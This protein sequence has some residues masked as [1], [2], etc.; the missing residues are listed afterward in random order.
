MYILL[1]SNCT[2]YQ[3]SVLIYV[4]LRNIIWYLKITIVAE[5]D[6]CLLDVGCIFLDCSL[7]LCF[8]RWNSKDSNLPPMKFLLKGL[9][10]GALS[11]LAYLLLH[12][13]NCHKKSCTIIADY[14][15]FTTAVASWRGYGQPN[16]SCQTNMSGPVQE[17]QGDISTVKWDPGD[18]MLWPSN[19]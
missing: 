4:C 12:S 17:R 15:T 16:T 19:S 5:F 3:I 18:G 9:C 11:Y 8:S 13:K 2:E 10:A 14:R 1:S 6:C 7:S